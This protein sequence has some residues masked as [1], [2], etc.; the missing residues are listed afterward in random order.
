MLRLYLAIIA[1][2]LSVIGAMSIATPRQSFPDFSYVINEPSACRNAPHFIFV[3]S[4]APKNFKYRQAIRYSWG[5]S[6]LQ[7][8][9]GFVL[10]FFLGDSANIDIESAIR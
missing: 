3:V 5:N 9:F 10:L 1:W 7:S 6:N 8:I 2:N 4:S